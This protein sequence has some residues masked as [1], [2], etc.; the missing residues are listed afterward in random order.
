GTSGIAIRLSAGNDKVIIEAGSSLQGAI[1][2]FRPG[3]SLDLPFKPFS[4]SGTATLASGNALQI[5]ENGS[6]FTIDLDPSQDFTNEVCHLI[7]D[8]VSGTLVTVSRHYD[9]FAANQAL[10]LVFTSDPNNL[11]APVSGG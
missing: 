1:A 9:F 5:S 4:S 10:N 8:A 3:D 11:P 7:S 6:T 2:N